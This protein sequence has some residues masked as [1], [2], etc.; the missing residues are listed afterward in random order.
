MNSSAFRTVGP[1]R[2]STGSN[3]VSSAYAV[4]TSSTSPIKNDPVV[5][6]ANAIP[7]DVSVVS[8]VSVV[9]RSPTTA[10]IYRAS[11]SSVASNVPG[12]TTR[13]IRR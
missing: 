5:T 9:V 6:S 1:G 11:A 12:V 2:I 7:I 10:A 8:V 3:R 13:L 4:S